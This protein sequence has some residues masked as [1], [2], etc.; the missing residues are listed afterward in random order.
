MKKAVAH[1][2]CAT[3]PFHEAAFIRDFHYD[4]N[5]QWRESF[6]ALWRWFFGILVES[7]GGKQEMRVVDD[8]FI[9]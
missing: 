9:I 5:K 2:L 8:I 7:D 1:D 4:Y 3:A 6:A